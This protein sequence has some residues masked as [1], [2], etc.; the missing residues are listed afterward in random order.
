MGYSRLSFLFIALIFGLVL[1]FSVI[2]FSFA[3]P[4]GDPFFGEGGLLGK[5]SVW[6]RVPVSCGA[7][8]TA[9]A[10]IQGNYTIVDRGKYWQ[11]DD[12]D[13]K[14]E[15]EGYYE[16]DDTFAQTTFIVEAQNSRMG[17]VASQKVEMPNDCDGAVD[18]VYL[19]YSG[20]IE[21][22]SIRGIDEPPYTYN[23]TKDNP[24]PEPEVDYDGKVFCVGH[25]KKIN[26]GNRNDFLTMD[27]EA[28][29]RACRTGWYSVNNGEFVPKI[30]TMSAEGELGSIE[31]WKIS[32]RNCE[33]KTRVSTTDILAAYG[34]GEDV[35]GDGYPDGV[36]YL[37]NDQ[38]AVAVGG[39]YCNATMTTAIRP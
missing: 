10:Q 18:S 32:S 9:T 37:H 8:E 3:S 20:D 19:P 31:V 11:L 16:I 24:H 2:P 1:L 35:D 36:Y 21:Y 23:R 7:G 5:K 25:F 22:V 26:A 34:R 39:K 15:G 30:V 29:K 13:P 12:P 6:L 4:E 27:E 14:G 28:A 17:V 33:D 38:W